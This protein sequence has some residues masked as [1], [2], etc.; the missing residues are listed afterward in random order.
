MGNRNFNSNP[1]DPAQWHSRTPRRSIY[2]GDNGR[3]RNR[4]RSRRVQITPR[5]VASNKKQQKRG[6]SRGRPCQRAA[7][8][9]TQDG[10]STERAERRSSRIYNIRHRARR[11]KNTGIPA[12]F[13]RKYSR[14]QQRNKLPR[15]IRPA[16][17]GRERFGEFTKDQFTE[18]ARIP[19]HTL[20][21][22]K[23]TWPVM[24]RK[25]P[26]AATSRIL[27]NVPKVTTCARRGK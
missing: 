24:R 6:N 21:T 12:K 16:A 13:H 11:T 14:R 15:D 22:R 25:T 19:T 9:R 17:G 27:K 1:P 23:L 7:G 4:S 3:I 20:D 8:A 26:G 18:S 2:R 10:E 5:N